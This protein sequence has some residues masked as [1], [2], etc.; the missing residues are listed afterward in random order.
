MRKKM[1]ELK[2]YLDPIMIEIIE[3]LQELKPGFDIKKIDARKLSLELAK[4]LP[5]HYPK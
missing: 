4:H 1:D 5:D 2:K 3:R